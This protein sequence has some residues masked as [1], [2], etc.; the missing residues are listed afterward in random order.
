M[1]QKTGNSED[2]YGSCGERILEEPHD[3]GSNIFVSTFP[4]RCRPI[5]AL[6]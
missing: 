2:A 4:V 6:C 5:K 1:Q 3:V